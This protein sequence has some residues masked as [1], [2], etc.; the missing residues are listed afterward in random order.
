MS[1]LI[2]IEQSIDDLAHFR[3]RHS[4]T[5]TFD[6]FTLNVWYTSCVTWS[7]FCTKLE[8]SRTARSWVI[9]HL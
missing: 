8:Q 1:N 6:I 5:L 3:F 7:N 9:D 2:K 4:V